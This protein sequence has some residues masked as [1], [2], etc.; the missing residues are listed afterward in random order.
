MGLIQRQAFKSSI[1]KYLGVLISGLATF[2]IY[3][4]EKE[5]YGLYSF[6]FSGA[7]LVSPVIMLG[8]AN[9]STKFHHINQNSQE[10]KGLFVFLI[11]LLLIGSLIL[12]LL[13]YFFKPSFEAIIID[14]DDD[15][16]FKAYVLWILPLAA[17]VGAKNLLGNYIANYG[18]IV[19]PEIFGNL[20]TRIILPFL[21]LATG[22][23]W[24]NLDQYVWSILLLFFLSAFGQFI[25]LT[26]FEKDWR[27]LPRFLNNK[28]VLVPV[29]SYGA[30]AALNTISNIIAV[31]IDTI[32]V[33]KMID[34]TNAGAYAILLFLTNI[35]LIP[36]QSIFQ[37][38]GPIVA[39]NVDTPKME[40][41]NR[42]YKS[43]SLIL[44]FA[45]M[46]ISGLILLNIYDLIAILP[47][48]EEFIGFF[49]VT[50]FLCLA[51]IFDMTTSV[52]THI[53]IY[54]KYYKVN[55]FMI[56]IMAVANIVFNLYLIPIYGLV[57]AALSTF[58]SLLI[59]N[60]A[61]LFFI[62]RVYQMQPF[63]LPSLYILLAGITLYGATYLIPSSSSP[64][65][66]IGWRSL[67]FGG[68]FCAMV[69]Y[70]KWSPQLNQLVRKLQ[71]Q[72]R[73]FL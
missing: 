73:D 64:W 15:P 41:V 72:I 48:S 14:P 54:S 4:A 53:I 25:Y 21:V 5:I 34:L 18:R 10:Y 65:L 9:I 13:F 51:H 27:A 66:N 38:S 63:S 26:F 49:G 30:F 22:L 70:F 42:I 37:I 1:V 62:Q 24:I 31:R 60:L 12:G 33:S 36:R 8:G 7:L 35:V 44:L 68:S 45:G 32:M 29:L 20:L 55:L 2:A 50:L 52:N 59:Y 3:S 39:R 43:S 56:L 19:V 28:K 57:G 11:G 46:L 47:K 58:L 69:Y 16:L 17:L 6:L 23:Q 61:K 71:R 67:L 40:E